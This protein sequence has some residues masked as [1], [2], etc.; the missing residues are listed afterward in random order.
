M[1]RK[2]RRTKKKKLA[3]ALI[4]VFLSAM[5]LLPVISAQGLE[6]TEERSWFGGD[7]KDETEWLMMVYLALDNN[8]WSMFYLPFLLDLQLASPMENL[9]VI[10][11]ADG[12]INGDTML[13]RGT[14]GLE[15]I[16][17]LGEFNM[18]EPDSLRYLVDYATSTYEA[19]KTLLYIMDHGGSWRGS[20]VDDSGVLGEKVD[21][22]TMPE[23]RTALEGYHFDV[24][25]W[26]ACQMSNLEVAYEVRDVADYMIASGETVMVSPDLSMNVFMPHQVIEVLESDPGIE[27]RE[28]CELFFDF[29]EPGAIGGGIYESIGVIQAYQAVDLGGVGDIGL[30]VDK[31]GVELSEL[32]TD[33]REEIT[34]ARKDTKCYMPAPERHDG[35]LKMSPL[36]VDL[37]ELADNLEKALPETGI[38]EICEEVK[39]ALSSAVIATEGDERSHGL[40]INFP[41]KIKENP[42]E[43]YESLANRYSQ[44]KFAEL[45]WDEFVNGYIDV[46]PVE[47]NIAEYNDVELTGPV[48]ADDGNKI[49]DVFAGGL[50]GLVTG[51][52]FAGL[53][54]FSLAPTVA[55]LLIGAGVALSL[56]LNAQSL[57]PGQ[58]GLGLLSIYITM[59]SMFFGIPLLLISSLIGIVLGI[60]GLAIGYALTPVWGL[61]GAWIGYKFGMP[62][63]GVIEALSPIPL[64]GAIVSDTV[65]VYQILWL[66]LPIPTLVVGYIKTWLGNLLGIAEMMTQRA[67]LESILAE[68]SELAPLLDIWCPLSQTIFLILFGLTSLI[69]G[70]IG[71][72]FDLAIGGVETVV[73]VLTSILSVIPIVGDELSEILSW[74]GVGMADWL[75]R[76]A[77]LRAIIP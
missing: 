65:K 49:D 27:P 31:L 44:L 53:L 3:T 47:G 60:I 74:L 18:G 70:V 35:K 21:L 58:A 15:I 23:F 51:G 64:I 43:V 22:L 12:Q 11:L 48:E 2:V 75:E 29:Y 63:E 14:N 68:Q 4:S 7:L 17:S 67:I 77:A 13:M 24:L 9:E 45:S 42:I 61:L 71:L 16:E 10:I 38:G 19:N 1:E 40:S 26:D 55:M 52:A 76:V 72:V 54:A 8:L 34:Q 20:C 39:V 73:W 66:Y 46:E 30:A 69:R 62:P 25:L 28:F 56:A 5:A 37:Y 41:L 6:E 59:L 33:Y 32:L 57:N 36:Y 50:M